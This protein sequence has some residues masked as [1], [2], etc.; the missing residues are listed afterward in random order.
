MGEVP[1][2]SCHDVPRTE[3]R[4]I[5]EQVCKDLIKQIPKQVC[6]KVQSKKCST[7]PEQVCRVLPRQECHAVPKEECHLVQRQQCVTNHVDDCQQKC[8]DVYWCKVFK[9]YG[10][11]TLRVYWYSIAY[12][13]QRGFF[14]LFGFANTFLTCCFHLI[15]LFR[16]ILAM[17]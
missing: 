11:D 13:S 6:A 10:L 5:P 3:C 14:F 16:E 4:E 2:E 1:R 7:V 15:V 12:Y 9:H 8:E 17:K